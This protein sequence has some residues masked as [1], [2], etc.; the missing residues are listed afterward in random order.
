MIGLLDIGGTKLAAATSTEPGALRAVHRMPT[1]AGEPMEALTVLLDRALDGGQPAAIGVSLPG[2]F[3]RAGGALIDP[4]GMPPGWHGL[5]VGDGLRQHYG[6][7]VVVEN[8]ANSAALAEA[9]WGAGAGSRTVLYFTVSTG[10]GTGVVRDRVL[11]TGRHDTEGGHQVLWPRWL[12]GPECH[13]GGAGCLEALA[14]GL[15][16]ERRFGVRAE[17]LDDAAAWEDVG[18]WLGLG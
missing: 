11:C 7:P 1:P 13:C 3:D 2:P 4:P 15:A 17:S 14:S 12:G 16:I 8:D 9:T 6:C 18:L 5:R 10:I